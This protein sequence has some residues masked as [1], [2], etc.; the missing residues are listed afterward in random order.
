MSCP[1]LQAAAASW[2]EK[3]QEEQE[4][5]QTRKQQPP[6]QDATAAQTQRALYQEVKS[7][8]SKLA[9]AGSLERPE[10]DHEESLKRA[11]REA[12]EFGMQPDVVEEAKECLHW[13]QVGNKV[14]ACIREVEDEAP[15]ASTDKNFQVVMNL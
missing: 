13:L 9:A 7:N 11:I 8:L 6:N 1:L 14:R 2:I 4:Q 5:K 10:S 3:E 15:F 12:E